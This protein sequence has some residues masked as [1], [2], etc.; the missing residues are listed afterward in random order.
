[1]S[2]KCG[3]S[4]WDIKAE[5]VMGSD[6]RQTDETQPDGSERDCQKRELQRAET[7]WNSTGS[8]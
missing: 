4:W 2:L 3:P 8:Q 1:M 7:S 5:I 6:A